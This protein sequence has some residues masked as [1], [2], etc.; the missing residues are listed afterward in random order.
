MDAVS[1]GSSA[2]CGNAECG[3]AECG[4]RTRKLESE[5][6]KIH[7]LI[8]CDWECGIPHPPLSTSSLRPKSPL[9]P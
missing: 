1:V 5:I 4:V 6:E 3:S 9:R 7:D 2:E 8:I